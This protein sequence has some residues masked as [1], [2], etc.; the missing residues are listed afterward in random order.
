M[1]NIEFE[2]TGDA[3]YVGQLVRDTARG[4]AWFGSSY[5]LGWLTVSVLCF[6]TGN[7]V[8]I[9]AGLIS[10]VLGAIS[11]H[12]VGSPTRRAMERLPP[13]STGPRTYTITDEGLS[14]ASPD[15]SVR[16]TWSSIT[17]AQLRPVAYVLLRGRSSF[18]YHIPRSY[19]TPEQDDELRDFLIARA[20]LPG[21]RPTS[22][23][24][25]GN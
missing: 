17:R 8:A 19:L 10:L 3:D 9:L 7:G 21:T 4:W 22:P 6:L 20:L 18:F 14:Y 11:W 2:T 24:T 25:P 1:V 23:A 5:C 15:G 16:V 13:Q 12:V